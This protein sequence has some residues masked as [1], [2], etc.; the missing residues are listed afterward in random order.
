MWLCGRYSYIT[1]KRKLRHRDVKQLAQG[2]TAGKVKVRIWTEVAVLQR[3][4]PFIQYATSSFMWSRLLD[5][6]SLLSHWP[7]CGLP[8]INI[9]HMEITLA[10]VTHFFLDWLSS[11]CQWFK[12]SWPTFPNNVAIHF[13]G[14][15]P[16]HMVLRA[17]FL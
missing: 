8:F 13:P 4:C 17:F 9:T 10:K 3:C 14:F 11:P 2:Q 12:Y 7:P 6:I 15:F 16:F 5:A 1:N